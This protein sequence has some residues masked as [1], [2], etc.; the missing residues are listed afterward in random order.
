MI[1]GE[2]CVAMLSD[3]G[4]FRSHSDFTVTGFVSKPI[5]LP[6]LSAVIG[7]VGA[8][9]M[10][11]FMEHNQQPK[12]QSFDGLVEAFREGV[13]EEVYSVYWNEYRREVLNAM[14]FIG[15]YSEK[16][17][18]WE[19]YHLTVTCGNDPDEAEVGE[20]ELGQSI[21]MMPFPTAGA[22]EEL[23][24]WDGE[25]WTGDVWSDEGQVGLMRGMRL[26]PQLMGKS[27]DNADTASIGYTVGGFVERVIVFREQIISEILWR[28]SDEP[29][30]M[31][32]PSVKG[33]A[34]L[35]Y[36][37]REYL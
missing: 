23:G 36:G 4:L 15:G 27:G 31:I 10:G 17:E 16:R 34:G 6:H 19:N 3:G 28:W 26:A 30:T 22:L 20:L 9:S 24:M 13:R 33:A 1:R 12:W 35:A 2:N 18:R 8:A 32:D 11:Y 21:D 25:N 5:R 14:F 7:F 37:K 29:G